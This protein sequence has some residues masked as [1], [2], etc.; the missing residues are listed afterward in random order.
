MSENS[1]RPVGDDSWIKII[2]FL[3]DRVIN[4]YYFIFRIKNISRNTSFLIFV[5]TYIFLIVLI[6]LIVFNQ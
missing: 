3:P 5:L 2:E 4:L 1:R 6:L